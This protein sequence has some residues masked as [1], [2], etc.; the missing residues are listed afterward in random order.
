MKKQG[1]LNAELNAAISLL[2]HGDII[3][4]ADCGLPIP[5]GVRLVDLSLVHGIPSF[6]QTLS[7]L[8]EDVIFEQCTAA[9]EAQGTVVETW[10][11]SKFEGIAYVSHSELKQIS[12]AARLFVRTGEATAFANVALTCGVSF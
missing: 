12:N 11:S 5:L 4:V 6:E 7:A 10:L 3:I 8:L 9:E 2:G 1:I